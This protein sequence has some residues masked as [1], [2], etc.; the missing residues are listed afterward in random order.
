M[1]TEKTE[2]RVRRWLRL[3][4]QA[5][6]ALVVVLLIV[7]VAENLGVVEVR[8]IVWHTEIRLAWALLLSAA[9]GFVAGWLLPRL[10]R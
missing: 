8:L 5:I 10:R 3:A 1:S 7:F 2:S 4:R 9:L 6:V